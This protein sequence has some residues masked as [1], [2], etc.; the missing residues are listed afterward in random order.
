MVRCK[1]EATIKPIYVA[2]CNVDSLVLA[3]LTDRS[4]TLSFSFPSTNS[5]ATAPAPDC[6]LLYPAVCCTYVMQYADDCTRGSLSD[7]VSILDPN[8]QESFTSHQ[9]QLYI[10]INVEM[11]MS[12]NCEWISRHLSPREDCET[13]YPLVVL[14]SSSSPVFAPRFFSFYYPTPRH[15]QYTLHSCIT[16]LW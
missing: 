15:L 16:T 7:F 8:S 4:R 11:L 2:T 12:V 6:V 10:D 9:H 5:L 14:R 1:L 3:S 13:P